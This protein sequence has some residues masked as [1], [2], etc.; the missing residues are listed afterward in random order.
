MRKFINI[1]MFSA[2]LLTAA[3][4]ANQSMAQVPP[5]PPPTGGTGSGDQ[6]IGGTAPIGGGITLLIV[7]GAGYA[8][9][10]IHQKDEE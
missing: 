4:C 10:K 9:K 5:P 2:V 1:L 7:M 6:P 3:V 8:I